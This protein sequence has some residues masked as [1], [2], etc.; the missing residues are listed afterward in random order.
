MIRHARAEE[1]DTRRYPNDMLRPL[2]EEG[3]LRFVRLAAKLSRRKVRPRVIATS[4]A[5]R[6]THTAQL[7]VEKIRNAPPIETLDALGFGGNLAELMEWTRDQKVDQVAWVGHEPNMSEHLAR[8][9]GAEGAS[10]RFAK[11]AVAAVTFYDEIAVGAATLRWFVTTR[12]MR[13]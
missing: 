6:C 1:R 5:V 9:I 7:L 13:S 4:P 8:L 10:I 12:L 3:R 2:S 11:G